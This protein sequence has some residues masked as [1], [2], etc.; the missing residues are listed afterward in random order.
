MANCTLAVDEGSQLYSKSKHKNRDSDAPEAQQL[1]F[2]RLP[3]WAWNEHGRIQFSP[4]HTEDRALF[5]TP[6][7]LA[8]IFG[9]FSSVPHTYDLA[10]HIR[11]TMATSLM[12]TPFQF[13]APVANGYNSITDLTHANTGQAWSATV[14]TPT[15]KTIHFLA[16]GGTPTDIYLEKVITCRKHQDEM[17]PVILQRRAGKSEALFG[18]VAEISGDKNPYVKSVAQEGSLDSGYGLLKVETT[19]APIFASHPS[20]PVHMLAAGLEPMPCKP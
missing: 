20:G 12:A 2:A 3:Q 1:V 4:H 7:Y 5:L 19:K 18:D 8:D 15:G 9:G 16:P 17:P 13:P 14:T 6:Q 10:W 11:G